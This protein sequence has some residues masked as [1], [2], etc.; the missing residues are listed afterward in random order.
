MVKKVV[1]EIENSG[2][3]INIQREKYEERWSKERKKIALNPCLFKNR[4]ERVYTIMYNTHTKK[5]A[6]VKIL[7]KAKRVKKKIRWSQE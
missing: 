4:L 3:N 1:G 2:R 7:K 5:N 6:T